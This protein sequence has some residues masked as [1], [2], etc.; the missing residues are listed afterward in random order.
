[1]EKSLILVVGRTASG[2]TEIVKKVA[3]KYG[4]SVVKSYTTRPPRKEEVENG[5]ENADHIFISEEEF[6]KLTGIVAET[7]INGYRYCT[8]ADELNKSDFYVIDPNGISTLKMDEID[9][10]LV[11]FYIYTDEKIRKGRYQA[12][13]TSNFEEREKAE[14]AQFDKYEVQH[15]YD[16]MIYN[17]GT[18]EQA[19]EVFESYMKLVLAKHLKE[20]E[21]AKATNDFMSVDAQDEEEAILIS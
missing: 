18:I 19:M 17:N 21:E 15:N 20:L 6:D 16:I 7:T 4:L 9:R 2:K 1:M 8:T 14:S 11:Q 3:K 10:R 12:R 5:L 13:T